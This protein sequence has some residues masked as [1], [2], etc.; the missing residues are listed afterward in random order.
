MQ[1]VVMAAL[2]APPSV[3]SGDAPRCPGRRTGRHRDKGSDQEGEIRPE[4]VDQVIMGN[5]LQAGLPD[6]T[7]PARPALRRDRPS[8]RLP[9][10]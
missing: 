10:P 5:V 1:D 3:V 2:A 8:I 4:R 6:G 7:S 9:S